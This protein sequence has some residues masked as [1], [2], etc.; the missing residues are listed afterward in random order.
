MLDAVEPFHQAPPVAVGV[1][2]ID[3]LTRDDL[4]GRAV[5]GERRRH[6]AQ[7]T[8]VLRRFAQKCAVSEVYAVKKAQ[9]NDCFFQISSRSEKVFLRGQHPVFPAAQAQERAVRAVDAVQPCL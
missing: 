3:G 8:G 9:C 5:K 1:D 6:C 4:L 7:R 2:E